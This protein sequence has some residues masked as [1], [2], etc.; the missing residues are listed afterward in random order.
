MLGFE[1]REP[2]SEGFHHTAM[3]ASSHTK[4]KR[5]TRIMAKNSLPMMMELPC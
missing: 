2:W 4:N 3:M 1:T 5:P